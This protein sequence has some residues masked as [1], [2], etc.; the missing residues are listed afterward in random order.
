MNIISV[1][2]IGLALSMDAFGVSLAIGINDEKDKNKYI[3][4][5]GLFQFLFA[6]C[7]GY[8]GCLFDTYIVSIPKVVGG[9]IIGIVGFLMILEGRKED[10][11]KISEASY[12]AIILSISVSIDAL[13]V[14]FTTLHRVGGVNLLMLYSCS[15]GLI[16]NLMCTISFI[17]SKYLKRIQFISKYSELFGGIILICFGLKMIFT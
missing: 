6:F 7:G 17:I 2:I 11:S 13:V 1:L 10:K 14:G 12:M 8:L 15:I 9:I 4:L 3:I 5:F 16:T